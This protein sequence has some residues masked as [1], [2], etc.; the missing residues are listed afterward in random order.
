MDREWP[1]PE[2]VRGMVCWLTGDG[3]ALARGV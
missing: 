2:E 3:V 1:A